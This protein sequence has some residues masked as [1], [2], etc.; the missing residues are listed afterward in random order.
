MM[1]E[2]ALISAFVGIGVIA[3]RAT[4]VVALAILSYLALRGTKPAERKVILRAM[5]PLFA[6]E[7]GTRCSPGRIAER[8]QSNHS[9]AH[10][11]DHRGGKIT[12][13]QRRSG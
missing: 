3:S 13:D 10:A 9:L 4:R 7:T 1:T 2:T 5:A 8:Q 12:R 6:C 11:A